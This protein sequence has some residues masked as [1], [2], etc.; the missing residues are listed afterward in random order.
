VYG[1]EVWSGFRP[2]ARW[3]LEHVDHVV[4]DCHFT[5]R[6]IESAGHRVPRSTAVVWDCVDL[7]HFA[8]GPVDRGVLARYGIPDPSTGFNL[9]TLGRMSP[10][11]S[12][13]GYDR[14]LEAFSRVARDLPGSRLVFAGRGGLI[15][16]LRARASELGLAERV[17]FTGMIREEDLP[18]VYR[19]AHAFSLVSDRGPG[20]G[21]GIPLTPLEAAACGLPIL[22]GN[23]DGSQEAIV[24]GRNGFVLDPFDLD[25]HAALIRRLVEND[26]ERARLSV[27]A[28][29]VAREVFSYERFREEHRMLL[30]KW[31]EGGA[32]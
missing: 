7:S 20:R 19:S 28:V 14:L 9:L 2:D 18:A 17:F 6:Y 8:P 25:A 32:G 5:A 10:D 29:E 4:A 12:H 1:S 22:V 23:H 15:E 26:A 27:G 31:L 21:E 11:A 30:V 3:G 16:V 13:K 24:D